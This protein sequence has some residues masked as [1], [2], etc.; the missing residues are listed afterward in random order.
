MDQIV[1]EIVGALG[2]AF[3]LYAAWS[4]HQVRRWKAKAQG[5]E[6]VVEWRVLGPAAFVAI[7]IDRQEYGRLNLTAHSRLTRFAVSIRHGEKL[8]TVD[9]AT[10]L[11]LP[12]FIPRCL[13]A[14]DGVRVPGV[15]F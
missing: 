6:I 4:L 1:W 12:F 11:T 2:V 13:I 9:S 15:R 8:A 3:L 14:F 5:H 7:Q 10:F